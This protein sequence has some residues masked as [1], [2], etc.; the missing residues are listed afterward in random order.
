MLESTGNPPGMGGWIRSSVAWRAGL[1]RRSGAENLRL[2][3][4]KKTFCVFHERTH[5]FTIGVEIKYPPANVPII[6]ERSTLYL[7][8]T[9]GASPWRDDARLGSAHACNYRGCRQ[10]EAVNATVSPEGLITNKT[11]LNEERE[12]TGIRFNEPT[13]NFT[14]VHMMANSS[15]CSNT[16]STA[17][18][19]AAAEQQSAH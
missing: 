14:I 16:S 4:K 8:L 11:C 1:G 18:H 12:N 13:A 7:Y 3:K 19:R 9:R 17:A 15:R 5:Q 6:S 10:I 2:E